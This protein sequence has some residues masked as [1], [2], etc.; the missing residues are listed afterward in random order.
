MAQWLSERLGRQFV[1]DNRPGVTGNLATEAVVRA[2]ADGYTLL[3]VTVGDAISATFYDKLNF[4]FICDIAP[5]A[6]LVRGPG[7]MV[8]NPSFPAKTVPEFIAYARA[9][10]PACISGPTASKPQA[11]RG[12]RNRTACRLQPHLQRTVRW[13]CF[14]P[15]RRQPSSGFKRLH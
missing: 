6:S 12:G 2:P 1:M 9:L 13:I 14:H 15:L 4:N 3:L 5:I 10:P 8:V 7:V 11:R